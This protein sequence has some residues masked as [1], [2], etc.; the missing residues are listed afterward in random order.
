MLPPLTFEK[1]NKKTKSR[2]NLWFCLRVSLNSG[3][4]DKIK[5]FQKN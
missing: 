1:N 2:K 3:E 4:N 5:I